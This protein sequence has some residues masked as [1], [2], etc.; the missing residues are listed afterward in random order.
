M[1]SLFKTVALITFFSFLTRILG[2]VF[3]IILS[4]VVGA[5]GVGLYQVASSIF[6]VL[7]TIISSGI[8]LVISRT[9]ANF[10]AN[11]ENKKQG[12]FLSVA[13]IFTLALSIII[14]LIVFAFQGL[15]SKLFADQSGVQILIVLLPSLVFSSVYCVLRGDLWGRGNYF[16][17]CVSETY[18]QVIR[19]VL[20]LLFINASY[21]AL[22][23]ALHLGATMS[24]AC[25]FSMLF[26]IVLFFFYGGKLR[27]L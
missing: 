7:L 2:F 22:E 20:A 25:F 15:F 3:R 26:V 5:E 21:S 17:L 13:L 18:E 19:M 23:N 9:S 12:S 14:A 24:V 6:M 1:K 27:S 8:P 11:K 10:Y 4:R 16:A